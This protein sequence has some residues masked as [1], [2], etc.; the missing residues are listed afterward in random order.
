MNTVEGNMIYN[1]ILA[2][3]MMNTDNSNSIGQ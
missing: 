3:K 2:E 1:Q